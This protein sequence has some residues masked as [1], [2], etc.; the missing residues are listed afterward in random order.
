MIEDKR[1]IEESFPVKEVSKESAREKN[2]RHGHISTLHIWWARRPLASSRATN[3]AAL[4]PAP[5]NI[6]EWQKERDF[7]IELSKWENSN[8]EKLLERA[9]KK[10]LEAN[11]GVPPKV[12]DPFGGGG[13]IPLE[14]L[15][16]GCETYSNDLNPV[17]VLIQKC[18]LE[19][20]QKYGKPIPKKQ[21]LAERP[22]LNEEKGQTK[23]EKRLFDDDETE[24]V[25][26]LVEDVKYWGNWVLEEAKK[27]IGQFY[28][29]EPDGSV[30]VG[31]IWARTIPCQNPACVAEIPLMRQYWLAKKAKKKV[32]LYPYFENNEVQFKIVG[33]GAVLCKAEEYEK[34][35]S[36]FKPENGTVARAVATCPVCGSTVE[37]TNTRRLFKDGKSGQ[38]MVAVVTHKPGTTGKKYRISTENDF[39]IFKEAE[40]YLHEKREKLFLEW[41]MDP[42]PDEEISVTPSDTMGGTNRV[43]NYDIKSWGDLFNGRQKL[44]LAIFVEKVR[45]GFQLMLKTNNNSEYSKALV[46]YLGLALDM[47]SGFNSRLSRWENTSQI[48]K[49]VYSRQALPMMWDYAESNAF[50]GSTGSWENGFNYYLNS[51]IHCS[52]IPAS[53]NV[54]NYSATQL[55]FKDNF[56]DVVLTDPPYYDNVPYS[57]LSDLFYVWLK[58]SLGMVYPELFSTPLT[59]KKNEIV[60]Y[61]KKEGG[62]AEA[63]RFFEDML[64]NAFMEIQRILKPKG[65]T[66]IV[67]AHKSTDGWETLIN[68]LLDSGL[69]ISGAWPLNTEMQNRILANETASLASSIYIVAR[70]MERQPTGFY[71]QV[72]DELDKYLNFKLERLWQE[73]IS[74]SDFF[75]AAIGSAIE[76]FGK[77]EQVMDYEGNV[78][79]ANRLLQDVRKIVTDFAV[80][81]ILH[82]GFAGEISDLTRF[83]VLWRWEFGAVKVRF[84]DAR[85]LA[86]SCSIDLALEWNRSGFITKD[87]EFIRVL[88]PQER[89]LESIK[90]PTGLVDVLHKVL[91]LWEK[92]KRQEIIQLLQDS[93]FGNS[94]AFYRVGQ[95]VSECLT[96]DNKEKKLLDGFLS[97]RER[98]MD[99]VK[100]GPDQTELF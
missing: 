35:P 31:Y 46:T 86:Q 78:V 71:N 19:Y 1:F 63:N 6:E 94:E 10:I 4:I 22:W 23:K 52:G 36:G 96:N 27:E 83:Y 75:I 2:I 7:I 16:L 58:R 74:G 98:L 56:F 66:T 65:L 12:L 42:V 64:K 15:R 99:D 93:G 26:P 50:S 60:A 40:T 88:G 55:A 43:L 20:P 29:E 17:A 81:Q 61:T 90:H 57:Y 45:N 68:S 77:Y 38:R 79:R 91:L 80:K 9:R 14:A 51:I 34:W 32:A 18:T 89:K 87:K 53:C 82:N 97:G 44:A 62:K 24:T 72:K 3:Y 8:N 48:I 84:D 73:G 47:Q 30:P 11:G 33:D 69:V 21:Y 41:G 92:S 70:K 100:K 76:V 54:Y 95:A 5:K 37:A 28:P 59:P 25:N 85:K 13:A 39:Q 67:Y 49:H